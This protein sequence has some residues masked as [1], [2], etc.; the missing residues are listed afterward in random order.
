MVALF[1]DRYF[2]SIT[3]SFTFKMMISIFYI[4]SILPFFS[5]TEQNLDPKLCS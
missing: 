5:T 1:Y 3:V 2:L 4:Y